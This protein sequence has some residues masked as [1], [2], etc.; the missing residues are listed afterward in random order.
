MRSV[1][2]VFVTALMSLCCLFAT[3][4]GRLVLCS[5]VSTVILVALQINQSTWLV[6]MGGNCAVWKY[7]TL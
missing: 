6:T 1:H 4:V 5:H 2:L 3:A 7:A